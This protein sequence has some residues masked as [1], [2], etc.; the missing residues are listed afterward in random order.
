MRYICQKYEIMI[1][2]TPTKKR[3]GLEIWGTYDNLNAFIFT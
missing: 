2:I 1:Y 3:I